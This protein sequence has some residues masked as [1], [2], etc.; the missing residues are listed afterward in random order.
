MG[1]AA[2]R[3][4]YAADAGELKHLTH[5]IEEIVLEFAKRAVG[6]RQA[7]LGEQLLRRAGTRAEGQLLGHVGDKL[8]EV[9]TVG[10]WRAL[11]LQLNHG[12]NALVEIGVDR[13]AAGAHLTVRTHGLGLDALLP[14]PLNRCIGV[15]TT[16]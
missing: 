7:L 6:V 15:A 4:V 8:L 12:A 9:G 14:Q 2:A 10:D 3:G 11:T 5:A 13:Q 1:I 16:L